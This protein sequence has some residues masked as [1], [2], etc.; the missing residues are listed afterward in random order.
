MLKIY[1]LICVDA[2]VKAKEVNNHNWKFA[3]LMY[4]SAFSSLFFMSSI[5]ISEKLFLNDFSYS[6]FTKNQLKDLS[7]VKMQA[8]LLYFVPMILLNYLLI[9]FNNR[10][11]WLLLKYK[12]RKGKYI[13]GFMISS[14]TLA[15]I[16][17]FI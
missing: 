16:C 1:Y 9:F 13:T 8:V 10:Y 2:I 5:I 17:I 15:L 4:L 6:L 12:P 11:E 14:I 7:Y 3:T